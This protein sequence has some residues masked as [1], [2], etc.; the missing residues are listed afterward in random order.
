MKLMP[1]ILMPL[2]KFQELSRLEGVCKTVFQAIA[3]SYEHW[4]LVAS[5]E[6]SQV[7]MQFVLNQQPN[8]STLKA[9]IANLHQITFVNRLSAPL[10]GLAQAHELVKK[11]GRASQ[12]AAAHQTS[13]AKEQQV[14]VACF[15]FPCLNCAGGQ[16]QGNDSVTRVSNPVRIA[17]S[18]YIKLV[19]HKRN[20]Y[21]TAKLNG[22][23]GIAAPKILI[24][25]EALSDH[26]IL[27]MRNVSLIADGGTIEKGNGVYLPM[28]SDSALKASLAT[29]LTCVLRV[30][31]QLNRGVVQRSMSDVLCLDRV[32]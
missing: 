16:P 23:D 22:P 6:I 32:N 9:L 3:S 10:S 17:R 4:L 11:V 13:E 8:R 27:Q 7:G 1:V 18:L 5:T 25:A 15:R 12:M 30:R 26:I 28:C 19:L 21:L 2:L 24:D 20:M 14:F 29:G 31:E